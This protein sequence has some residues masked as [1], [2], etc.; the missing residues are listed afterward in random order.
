MGKAFLNANSRATR[1]AKGQPSDHG[2]T[3]TLSSVVNYFVSS[4]TKETSKIGRLPLH[5][6]F[7]T[8]LCEKALDYT[9]KK[10]VIRLITSDGSEFLSKLPTKKVKKIGSKS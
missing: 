1:V 9:K 10:H 5:P 4:K 8:T 6:S 7:C 2:R 3:T